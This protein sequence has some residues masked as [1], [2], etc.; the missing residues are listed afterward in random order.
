MPQMD[1]YDLIA[2]IRRLTDGQNA[3]LPAVA[4][5]AYASEEDRRRAL[6]AGFQMHFSKP[7][8]FD[9]FLEAVIK[10]YKDS[11]HR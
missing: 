9:R 2:R 7:F 10:L 5:T 1:G 4:L 8:D 3:F 11:F 6:S